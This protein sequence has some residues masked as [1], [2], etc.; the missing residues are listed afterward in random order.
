MIQS[1]EGW[2]VSVELEMTEPNI[3]LDTAL[4]GELSVPVTILAF[5]LFNSQDTTLHFRIFFFKSL[6]FMLLCRYRRPEDPSVPS[7]RFSLFLH[8]E[9]SSNLSWIS[10]VVGFPLK[11]DNDRFGEHLFFFVCAC[12]EACSAD[13]DSWNWN[14]IFHFSE[15][16]VLFA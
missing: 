7:Q 2:L 1:L 11:A 16:K 4:W 9:D 10:W 13:K 12:L 5:V 3:F 6:S 15:L 14:L 8:A